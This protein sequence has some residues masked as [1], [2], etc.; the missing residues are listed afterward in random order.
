M[1]RNEGS[2][3]AWFLAGI[4]M[5]LAGG[6]L[7]AP[8]AG[9]ETRRKLRERAERGRERLR[10]VSRDAAERG[11]GIMEDAADSGRKAYERG[12]ELYRKG[13]NVAEETAAEIEEAAAPEAPPETTA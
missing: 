7:L 12:K 13:R 8:E 1:A 4:A 10:D 9:E 2:D 3:L 6:L 5:G 11:R